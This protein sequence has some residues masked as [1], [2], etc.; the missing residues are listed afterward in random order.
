[1]DIEENVLLNL[2]KNIGSL[3]QRMESMEK[4]LVVM[5]SIQPKKLTDNITEVNPNEFA[6]SFP[7]DSEETEPA[8]QCHLR[9]IAN[10]EYTI[11]IAVPFPEDGGE[12]FLFN[13]K[14]TRHELDMYLKHDPGKSGEYIYKIIPSYEKYL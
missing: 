1:M 3:E 4:V 5:N 10:S 11:Y 8:T 6:Y 7:Y 13:I 9:S 14:V 2:S 12:P